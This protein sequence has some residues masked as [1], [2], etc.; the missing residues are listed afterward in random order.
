[1]VQTSYRPDGVPLAMTPPPAPTVAPAPQPMATGRPPLGEPYVTT[2]VLISGDVVSRSAPPPPS[3]EATRPDAQPRSD[4]VSRPA[5]TPTATAPTR[6]A[7]APNPTASVATPVPAVPTRAAAA[8]TRAAAAPKPTASVPAPAVTDQRAQRQALLKHAIV[9]TCGPSLRDVE[10]ELRS[11]KEALIR[12]RA[13]SKAEADRL[14][15]EIQQI[16]ELLP[17]KLDVVIK[18]P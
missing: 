18:T 9:S 8:P 13:P 12:F 7:A 4:V 14:W 17:Y 15:G 3:R 6:A 11:A 10:V 16:P 5:P 1:M 2:G